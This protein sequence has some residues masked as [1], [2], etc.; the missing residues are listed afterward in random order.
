MR[1]IWASGARG[2][3]AM[4]SISLAQHFPL[5]ALGERLPVGE[6]AQARGA[7]GEPS[8]R[9]VLGRAG[10]TVDPSVRRDLHA[11]GLVHLAGLDRLLHRLDGVGDLGLDRGEGLVTAFVQGAQFRLAGRK[12]VHPGRPPDL[13]GPLDAG[14]QV[15]GPRG[16][17]AGLRLHAPDRGVVLVRLRGL[18][19]DVGREQRRCVRT[20]AVGALECLDQFVDAVMTVPEHAGFGV[21]RRFA[22]SVLA[23][24]R[25]Q[26]AQPRRQVVGLLESAGVGRDALLEGGQVRQEALERPERQSVLAGRRRWGDREFGQVEARPQGLDRRPGMVEGFEGHGVALEAVQ[27]GAP[28]APQDI[29]F[30]RELG[31][32]G[33]YPVRGGQ[34]RLGPLREF[35]AFLAQAFQL[36]QPVPG[37]AVDRLVA[38]AGVVLERGEP[39]FVS[40]GLRE[41]RAR[42]VVLHGQ[43][44][45]RRLL[46]VGDGLERLL[47][48]LLAEP[49]DQNLGM[50]G[51]AVVGAEFREAVGDGRDV[52]AAA[53]RGWFVEHRAEGLGG[54]DP[55]DGRGAYGGVRVVPRDSQEGGFRGR[56]Q[57]Q[58][59]L[60]PARGIRV[61]QL[62][63][64]SEQ[65]RQHG[66]GPS[67]GASAT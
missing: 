14:Q 35:V 15:R 13:L 43:K 25:L 47:G 10:E 6:F 48:R 44:G 23:P 63:L 40:D 9:S 3:S 58:H 5:A 11:R 46:R 4:A 16:V 37:N 8:G 39:G 65:S 19:R 1:A 28:L 24:A 22:V 27:D 12:L 55:G 59:G 61:R 64:A 26:F 38:G 41:R 30:R 21:G 49:R 67:W 18:E 57:R 31:V 20:G 42:V 52:V 7:A 17:S 60:A 33:T 53:G 54:G 34:Q 50:L 51:E 32:V 56:V 45:A 29:A 2:R 36:R 62:R 66:P